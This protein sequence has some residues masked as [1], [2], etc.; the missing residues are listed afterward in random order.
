M[1][2]RRGNWL[3]WMEM[4][5]CN[6]LNTHLNFIVEEY[7]QTITN[8]AQNPWDILALDHIMQKNVVSTISKKEYE[9]KG[10]FQI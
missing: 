10:S 8:S 3:K 2:W 7:T 6:I 4:Q 5:H 9:I 1:G